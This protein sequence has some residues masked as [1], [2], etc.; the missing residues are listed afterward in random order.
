MH[1]E[2]SAGELAAPGS[3]RLGGTGPH[4]GARVALTGARPG[5]ATGA[6]LLIHGRGGSALDI[7]ELGRAIAPPGWLLVAPQAPEGSWYPR[8]FLAPPEANEPWL[9]SALEVLD[10]TAARLAGAGLAGERLAVAGFSQGACLALEWALRR[11]GPFAA[12]VAF[13]GARLGALAS[14]RPSGNALAGTPALVTGATD[15]PHVPGPYLQ[16]T[17]EALAQQGAAV[18]L[19]V[20][21][22]AEHRIRASELDAAR[23]VLAR[24]GQ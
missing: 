14:G 22:D 5:E 21:R 3:W 16:A 12:L 13:S 6:I 24:A 15:D 11:G 17:A 20:A 7:L 10:Q 9:G 1:G 19:R 4:A 23:A 2:T 8:R 18:E